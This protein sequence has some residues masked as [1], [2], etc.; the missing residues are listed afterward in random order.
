MAIPKEILDGSE[1]ELKK[2]LNSQNQEEKDEIE[3]NYVT[4]PTFFQ[5]VNNFKNDLKKFI[6]SG[7]VVC[8]SDEY[9]TRLVT[10]NDCEHLKRKSMRCGA[11]GCLLEGKARMKSSHCPLGRWENGKEK[12]AKK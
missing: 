8:T 7:A 4:P 6:N 9:T 2:Y 5:M 1:K 12:D 10:C 3:S 11:C